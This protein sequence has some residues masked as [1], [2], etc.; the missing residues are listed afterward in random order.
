[1]TTYTK[2]DLEKLERALLEKRTSVSISGVSVTFASTEDLVRRIE[3][4]RRQL[5]AH[6]AE[7]RA[8]AHFSKGVQA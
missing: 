7:Q 4:V 2:E 1:M 6:G 3:Y 8:L 5:E